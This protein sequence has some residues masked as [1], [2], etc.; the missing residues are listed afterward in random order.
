MIDSLGNYILDRTESLDDS[1]ITKYFIERDNSKILRLLDTEQYLLEGSRGVGKTMLMK[2]TML[3]SQNEFGKNSILPVWVSFEESIR[4]E[5]ISILT[6][7]IDPFLQWT[8]G[9][10]LFETLN[11]LIQLKPKTIDELNKKLASIFNIPITNNF[12]KYIAILNNYINVLE[13]GD[14]ENN[15]LLSEHSPSAEL[16]EILDNPQSFKDFLLDIINDYNLS[17]IIFLFDE[18]AHVFSYSQQEK[19]F[20]FFKT[21]RD[22]KIACK[23]AVYPG[24]TNYGKYF[25]R[26][27]DA[28]ELKV[29]WSP[30]DMDDVKYI[31]SI[32]KVRLKEYDYKYWN[33]LSSNQDVLKT[34]CICS[35][36]NPRFAFHIIDELENNKAFKGNSVSSQVLIN[37][38]R[39][40]FNIKWK[41]FETLKHRL[42]KYEKYIEEA[43]FFVKQSVLPNLRLWN[44]KQRK[45]KSKLSIGFYITTEAYDKLEKVFS[46]L[47][48]SNI[49]NID[50]SK[51]SVGHHKYSYY[52]ALNPSL[53]FTDLIIKDI[54]ELNNTSIAIENNQ[55]YSESTSSIKELIDNVS[56]VIYIEC[57]NSNC[58]FKTTDEN[59][60]FC[61]K[62]GREIEIKEDQSLY[63]ILRSHN[64]D[65]LKISR[66]IA[67]RLKK[68]F[69]NIGDIYDSEL[70]DLRMSYIQDVRITIIKNAALEYMAG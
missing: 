17:R 20:T 39:S 9:K 11:K 68:K 41:E 43:E 38:I 21:L 50:Y 8:M 63:K 45:N 30:L 53:L 15:S 46:V 26:G 23:A 19:F 28:K 51:K 70:D 2:A 58:D 3:R 22:P 18:A 29:Q 57:S 10:I 56:E 67:T 42:I 35:N 52:V 49:I 33:K 27:Q 34:L 16:S 36:G 66:K 14:I 59:Y 64:I 62:C 40:V 31:E 24:I 13:K 54:N 37:S 55:S 44:D 48:Y 12:E 4:I 61:P 47:S 65:H 1:L 69:K 5:R 60:K 7:S 32:I 25:E 6:N